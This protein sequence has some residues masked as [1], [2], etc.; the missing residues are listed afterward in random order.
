MYL[1]EKQISAVADAQMQSLCESN[2]YLRSCPCGAI[3]EIVP[4]EVNF[5]AKDDSGQIQSEEAAIHMS[6]NRGRCSTCMETFCAG[7][8]K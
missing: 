5:E 2:P 7:C 3:M 1:S 6:F 4:G 8:Q